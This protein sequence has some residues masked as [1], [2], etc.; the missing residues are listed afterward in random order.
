MA[1]FQKP[2]A[3]PDAVA[4][5]QPLALSPQEVAELDE[6][7]W[8]ARVYR[9]DDVPQLTVRAVL[10][11]TGLGF[12][13]AFTNVYVG[14][15]SGWNLG[16]AMAA[17]ILSF[18]LWNALLKAGIARSRMSI[19]ESNCMQ[20]TASAAG[21]STGAM[22]S[23]SIPALLLLSANVENP[24]GQQL[25]WPVLA[26]WILLMALLGVTIAIP[27]KRN[28]INRERLKFP[29]GIA[30][31]TM[32]QSLYSHG[33]EAVV[34]ARA[35]M[36]AALVAGT[37]PLLMDLKLRAGRALLPAESP[38][39][40][41]LPGRGV[42]PKTG[43]G[44]LPS[45][46]TVV[47]DHKLVMV[48]AGMIAGM[49]VC[50]SM[51]VGAVLLAF[52]VGPAGLAA[53]AVSAPASAWSEI[54]VWIGTPLLVVSGLLTFAFQWRTIARA[55]RGFG[56]SSGAARASVEVPASW[57]IVGVTVA[58][59]GLCW[60]GSA[61]FGIPWPLGVVAVLMTAIL[62]LVACRATGESDV[63]PLGA[64]GN[65]TQLTYGVL[66][67]QNATA[68]L[69][70]AGITASAA[71]S[72]ADLLID[73]KSGYLLGANPRRQFV[74]QFL[75]IFAGTAATTLAFY[76]LVPDATALTGTAT[77]PPAFPAPA[78]QAWL[79][80][81][82]VFQRGLETL[83]PLARQG[84]LWATLAGVLLVLLE[85]LPSKYRRWTPSATGLGLGFILPFQYALSFFIGATVVA[86]W[87]ARNQ[88]SAERYAIPV[89]SGF[90]AGESIV[91]VVVAALNN[92]ALHR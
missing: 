15:K 30:A 60:L 53:G 68:T 2:A 62:S 70:T 75:G 58:S 73:L 72:S 55:F 40:N 26:G 88:D 35:L 6:D 29:S 7:Q 49:R 10:T 20:S 9:G 27:M 36:Y 16:V 1:L 13:L 14:L 91:G 90:I 69:V 66:I 74:A 11:G 71:G 85:A 51:L 42:D 39:F 50:A 79:A 87:R 41:F 63:T 86:I 32:L 5:S 89:S 48:A 46:W 78:A 3:T 22:T 54:G 84:M 28:M 82:R 52:V 44:L 38:I 64:V 23:A 92:F 47:L 12:V 18:S 8:Y 57:C 65:L 33:A 24:R 21:Y 4:R 34:K 37:T 76:L 25:P 77:T 81:A 43:A 45:D 83:H 67:P 56:G 19:L 80:L 61:C 59:F 17:C 31:A